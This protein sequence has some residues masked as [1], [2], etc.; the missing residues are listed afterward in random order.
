MARLELDRRCERAGE[1]GGCAF[2]LHVH[3]RHH[4][5][6]DEERVALGAHSA[7]RLSGAVEIESERLAELGLRIS[8]HAHLASRLLL[9]TPCCLDERI[10]DRH[11]DDLIDA[12]RLNLLSYTAAQG[13]SNNG[14]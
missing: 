13:K 8:Q 6:L 7:E 3:L 12:L 11:A 1:T 9:I 4:S 2:R 5:V 14:R 10:I